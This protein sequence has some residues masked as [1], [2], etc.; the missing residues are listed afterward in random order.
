MTENSSPSL[1]WDCG[2]AYEL[3]ISLRVLHDPDT[4]GVR[5]S[6]A[7]GVRSRIPAAERRFLEENV[8]YLGIPVSWLHSLP[9]PKDAIA[10]LWAMRQIPAGQRIFVLM[11]IATCSD[12]YCQRLRDISERRAWDV[13]DLDFFESKSL[14]MGKSQFDRQAFARHLD[15]WARPEEF[16]ERYLAAL[17]AYYQVFFEQ[18][19]KRVKPVL[20]A[21]LEH[22]KELSQTLDVDALLTN[23]S[24]GVRFGEEIKGKEITLAPAYWTTPL[25]VWEHLKENHILFLFGARPN[26]MSAIPGE[27]VPDG[28]L[29]TLKAIADPTRLKILNY[30]SNEELTPSELSRRLHLR[31]PTVTHHL[32]ELRLAGLV[33][34]TVKGQEK[35]Y[36][37]RREALPSTFEVL[38]HFL[39]TAGNSV[40]AALDEGMEKVEEKL[41]NL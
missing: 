39:D 14:K 20:E 19:E 16:G 41:D 18:E 35:L 3:F 15:W 17:Q 1:T 5:A 38:S 10:A 11:D 27:M 12:D 34:L 40:S 21:G 30:L 28:L 9:A 36:S 4:Y 24:Q 23:L 22:A 31:A 29:R 8:M 6:W 37:T 33:N 2:T 32:S 26:D 7:A 13:S 25:I